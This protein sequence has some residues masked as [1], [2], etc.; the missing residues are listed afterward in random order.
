MVKKAL[1]VGI[2]YI[3]TPYELRGC[4]NDIKNMRTFLK[5]SKEYTDFIMLSDDQD[6]K[7]TKVNIMTSLKNMIAGAVKGDEFFFHYSGHGT[8]KRDTNGDEESGMD[9]CLVPLDYNNGMIIDDEIRSILVTLPQ[10]VTIYCVFDSCH[11]GTGCDLRCKYEDQSYYTKTGKPSTY[12]PNDW[13]LKQTFYEFKKYSKTN[14]NIYLISGCT[15]TQTS[16]DAFEGGMPS[17]ALTYC[18]LETLKINYG[19][20]KWKILLKDL[21]AMLKIKGYTQ[22]PVLS[23]G[24]TLDME[25][26]VFLPKVPKAIDLLIENCNICREIMNS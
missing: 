9:S 7:P 12:E 20:C 16:A 19:N 5:N 22:R 8:L 15:D 17:G 14:A 1:L 13:Q 3:G 23:S 26:L 4:I 2:N 21:N 18:L 10:G 25:S 24:T 6:N 11:S